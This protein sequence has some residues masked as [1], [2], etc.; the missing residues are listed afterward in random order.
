[1]DVNVTTQQCQELV[2][3]NALASAKFD[4]FETTVKVAQIMQACRPIADL[5]D[6]AR[7]ELL[8]KL[9]KVGDEGSYEKTA[10]GGLVFKDRDGR[11]KFDAENMAL[12]ATKVTVNVPALALVDT[13]AADA[14][15]LTLF[16]LV[17]FCQ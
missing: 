8:D 3:S 13:Q 12:L 15:P 4:K 5:Y 6:I 9:V 11:K 14:T 7:R 17:P 1:M 2:T 10:D 16:P